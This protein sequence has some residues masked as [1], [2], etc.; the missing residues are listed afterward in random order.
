MPLLL[1]PT[2]R[3]SMAAGAATVFRSLPGAVA[4]AAPDGC[5]AGAHY[6]TKGTGTNA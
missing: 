4:V 1:V 3:A 6:R 2:I 5:T